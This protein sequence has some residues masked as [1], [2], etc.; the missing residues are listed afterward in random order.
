MSARLNGVKG[1]VHGESDLK[2]R[3]SQRRAFDGKLS[4]MR[5]SDPPPNGQAKTAACLRL[6]F[7]EI[8][9]IKAVE[10]VLAYIF[11]HTDA[12]VADSDESFF[13]SEGDFGADLAVLGGIA[14]G[15]VKENA[16]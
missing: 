2:Y 14:D 5:V 7:A 10:D 9:L 13:R 8:G 11:G 12:G 16:K 3:P 1:R 15:V 4:P 6:S